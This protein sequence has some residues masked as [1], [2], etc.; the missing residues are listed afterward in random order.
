[1]NKL[2]AHILVAGVCLAQQPAPSGWV[3]I[4]IKD[5]ETLRSK[6]APPPER[7]I[8]AP[9]EATLTR[10]DYDLN[11]EGSVASGQATLTVDVLKAGWVS[12]PLPQ[13]LLV[14]EARLNGQNIALISKPGSVRQLAAVLTRPGRSTV[15]LNVGFGVVSAGAEERLSLPAG[16]SGVTQAT[17]RLT[18]RDLDVTVGGGFLAERSPDRWLAYAKGATPLTFQWRKRAEERPREQVPLRMRA[19]LVQLFGLGEDMSTVSAEI[20]M[21]VVQGAAQQIKLAVPPNVTI[22]QVPGANVSDWKVEGDTL[23]VSFLDPVERAAKF[24]VTGETRLPSQGA[25]TIPVLRILDAERETGGVAVEMLG[26]GEIKNSRARGLDPADAAAL[27]QTV[28]ARQSPSMVAFRLRPI[29]APALEL[30]VARY[31]QQAVLTANIEEAR[32]RV[33]LTADGKTLVQARYAVRNNQRNF[34]A[35]RLP[36]GASLWSASLAGQP[37]RP[38]KTSDGALLIPLAKGRAGDEAP[39]FGIEMM[40]SID[41]TP[42]TAKGD[43]TLA[44]PVLDLPVSRSGVVLY[45]PPLY[46]VTPQPGAFRTQPYEQPTSQVL[47]NTAPAPSTPGFISGPATLNT[48]QQNLVDQYRNDNVARRTAERLPLRVS[49]PARGPSGFLASEL[50]AENT[51]AVIQLKYQEDKVGGV[52]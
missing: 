19:S 35:V 24:V 37:A 28:A 13:G 26:A 31:D 6:A 43:A 18:G 44:L 11:V 30:D 8:A 3:V 36:A 41:G 22:N 1:M 51:A 21:E 45:V 7:A 17:V 38:G 27:G 48:A 12:I 25:I 49:F 2:L 9:V 39:P 5:Y 29:T 42:W 20:D 23:T 14:R 33:L 10:I 46:R 16:K 50:T 15:V 34:L 32:Y 52:R 47:N 4:P 40:Y